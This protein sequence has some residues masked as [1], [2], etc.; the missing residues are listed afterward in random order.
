MSHNYW[1]TNRYVKHPLMPGVTATELLIEN[2]DTEL[3]AIIDAERIWLRDGFVL[4]ATTTTAK[5]T[6]DRLSIRREYSVDARNETNPANW[7]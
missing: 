2:V 6:T 7:S 5:E 1:V 4:D 3:N